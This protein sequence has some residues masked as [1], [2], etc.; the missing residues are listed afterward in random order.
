M[1]SLTTYED[2]LAYSK[3]LRFGTQAFIGG[4]FVNSL[5]GKTFETVS[6]ISGKVIASVAETDKEDVDLAV[7]AARKAFDT[8]VWRNMAPARRKAIMLKWA[9]LMEKNARELALLDV[10]DMGKPIKD[11]LTID[12]PGSVNCYRWYAEAIDKIYDEICPSD[13]GRM[14]LVMREPLGVVACVV[15]W[16]FPMMMTSWKVAPALITGNSI[17]LKPAE[18]SPL[19]AI[20]IAELAAEAGIPEGVFNV[21]PGYGPTTG[22]ALGRHPDVDCIAFTG[23]TEVGKLFMKYSAESNMKAVNL[24]CGGKSPHIIMS[25]A[26][27]V[28]AAATAAAWAVFF[29]QG[30]AC[31][32]GTR[33]L[34]EA[35]VKDQVLEKI[36]SIGQ[37]ITVGDPLDPASQMG[38]VVDDTQ[39]NRILGYIDDG[40]AAGAKIVLGGER[41]REE[42]GGF[43]IA[44][45]VFDGVD[46][47]MRIAQ[48]EIFGPVMSTISFK[49]TDEAIRIAN[50]TVYGLYAA[51]WTKDI[52][53]AFKV[54][55]G[56]RAGAVN[57][58]TY[59][60]GDITTPF[61]G[62]KQSGQGRDKSLHAM[63]KYTALKASCIVLS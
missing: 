30:Q 43:Y 60:G 62:F 53:K 32:A 3:S 58:N 44:P 48:E 34:V 19:S 63:E 28:N 12:L 26:P 54:V 35:S 21:L 14:V 41:R 37:S 4:K 24:E 22:Q 39:M 1:N 15:P 29:N 49:D 7:A 55:R 40:K 33:L 59:S 25:D 17:I 10:L 13:P 20:R 8:G 61:G 11:A 52:N 2:N 42:S 23:S 5:S 47:G 38:A 51:V 9:D 16:N 50:D 46:N 57:V 27:D 45:T 6:P 18:Q 31:N 56:V 36:V